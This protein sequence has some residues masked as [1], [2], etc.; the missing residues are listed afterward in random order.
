MAGGRFSVDSTPVTAI[1]VGGKLTLTIIISCI[2]AASSGL[3]FGYDIGI[4]GGVTT[5]VPF[6][7]K[8]FP[9]ILRKAAETEANLYCV[10]DSQVLTLFTSSLYL[11]GLVSSLAASKV[12]T[13]YGR[14]NTILYGGILF[15]AGGA[16]NGGAEN[17]PMLII[18]RVLLGLGVGFANQAAPLYLAEIAPPKWRGAIGISLSFFLGIGIVAANCI[19]YGIAMHT[20]GWRLSL[21][22]AVVPAAIMTIGSFLISDTPNSLVERGQIDQARKSL[23]KIRGSSVNIE[24]ELDEL[25]KWTAIAESVKQKPFKTIF[26][27]EYRPHLVM[28][29]AIPFFNQLTGINIVAFYSP[30]LFQSVGLGHD[31]ALLSAIILGVANLTSNLVSAGIVDRFGRRFLFIT[32]GIVMFVCLIGVSILLAVVTGVDGTNNISKGNAILLLVLLCL[33]TAGFGW[34]WGPLA[35][36]IPSEIFPIN[37][38]TTGQNI[39][40][41]L[42]FII[43][44]VLSQTFLTMLCHFKFGVFLFYAFWVAVMTLFVI[45]FLPETKGISLDSMYTICGK[46]WFWCRFVK[47]ED[48]EENSL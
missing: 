39:T 33:Y 17:I 5:M 44:F 35:W 25:I 38:R 15:L 43:I 26:K 18:G 34:S 2:V 30:N 28:A 7:Q 16:I 10:Y 27:R 37:I 1:S 12:T 36:L 4:S 47:G 29:F 13:A 9:D 3:L 40:A 8:F 22:L 23:H 42:S 20:W 45:F 24:P 48:G 6:L 41:G 32:G 46:H 11:A 31:G 21:G 19:N 14:R